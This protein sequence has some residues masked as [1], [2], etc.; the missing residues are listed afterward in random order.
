MSQ[1]VSVKSEEVT[2]EER[3]AK[4]EEALNKWPR[5]TLSRSYMMVCT[6][7]LF[8]FHLKHLGTFYNYRLNKKFLRQHCKDLKLYLTP[9]LNDVLYLHFKG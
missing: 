3:K 4:E 5:L 9:H 1:D 6:L 2:E 7:D 8:N